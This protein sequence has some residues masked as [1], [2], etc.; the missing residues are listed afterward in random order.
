LFALYAD[1]ALDPADTAAIEDAR[2]KDPKFDAEIR[3]FQALGA[4]IEALTAKPR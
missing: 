4:R 2:R 1:G 3:A